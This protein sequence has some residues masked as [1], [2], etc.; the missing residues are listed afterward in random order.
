MALRVWDSPRQGDGGLN[1]MMILIYVGMTMIGLIGGWVRMMMRRRMTM[2]K[3]MTMRRRMMKMVK[4][5]HED[6][7]E[8]DD[9]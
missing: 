7:D 9:E 4:N 6:D 8:W 5:S 1:M 3:R 2:R